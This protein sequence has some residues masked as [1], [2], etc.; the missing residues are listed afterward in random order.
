MGGLFD[1]TGRV[2]LVT[3]G[4]SGIGRSIC[5]G[6]A[7]FGAH[8]AVA[9]INEKWANETAHSISTFGHE[10]LAIKVDVTSSASVDGMVRATVSRFNT[11]DILVANAGGLVGMAFIHETS[12]EV[13]DRIIALNFKS[14]FLCNKAVLPFML[15]QKK[16]SIINTASVGAILPG[17]RDMMGSIYDAA[18]AGV[19]A[20]TRKAAGEY[21]KDGIRINAIAPGAIDGTNFASDRKAVPPSK[22]VLDRLQQGIERTPLGRPGA[23]D[24]L[25]GI[26]IYLASDAASY[27][28]GQVFVV[29]GGVS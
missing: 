18:K 20:F 29:D 13:W 19:I 1:L 17:D 6:L 10:T 21:G 11:V 3:G 7:E 24:E 23:P 4:G 26:V 22:E 25:K 5:E 9:D 12:E 15:K 2:A 28:T 16:G 14:V 8:V 27:A